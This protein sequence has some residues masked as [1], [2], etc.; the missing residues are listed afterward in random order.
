MADS[1]NQLLGKAFYQAGQVMADHALT[2]NAA[3]LHKKLD[4]IVEMLDPQG[5]RVIVTPE[6]ESVITVNSA[7]HAPATTVITKLGMSLHTVVGMDKNTGQT[8]SH[9]RHLHQSI[10]TILFTPIGSRVMRRDFGSGLFER[11]D[12]PMNEANL[13][14]LF[15][16]MAEALDR[17]EPRFKLKRVVTSSPTYDG[18]LRFA[19]K[20]ELV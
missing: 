9:W 4:L 7:T 19:L 13:L 17:W 8:I 5:N 14:K 2:P 11:I 18:R 15:M 16:T 3:P 10:S 1:F 20:G 12:Q 6:T